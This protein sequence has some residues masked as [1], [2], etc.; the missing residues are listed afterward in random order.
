MRHLILLNDAKQDLALIKE[1]TTKKWDRHQSLK[2]LKELRQA[3]E[4]I[5]TNPNIGTM[6]VEIK[7]NFFSFP[8]KSHVVYYMFNAEITW[9]VRVLHKSMLPELH[10]KGIKS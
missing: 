8:L 4:L 5:N 7:Y 3:I 6:N 10:L 1:Y 9:V 2:Y